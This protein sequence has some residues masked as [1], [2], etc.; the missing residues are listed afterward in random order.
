MSD[1]SLQLQGALVAVLRGSVAVTAIV[2]SR[3]FDSVPRDASGKATAQFPYVTLGEDQVIPD[4]ADCFD[5]AE[6]FL[7]LHAWSRERGYPECKR[8]GAAIS[9]TLGGIELTIADHRVVSLEF[10]GA[11]YLRDPDGVISF[12]ALTEPSD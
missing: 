4:L 5:G 8:L 1:A 12:R 6:H 2:E 7:T 10:D 11:Q 3:I 9:D